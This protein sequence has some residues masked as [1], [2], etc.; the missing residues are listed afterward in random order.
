MMQPFNLKEISLHV[1]SSIKIVSTIIYRIKY[2]QRK[3][4]SI[5]V[6]FIMNILLKHV[7]KIIKQ[8]KDTKNIL[9]T[10]DFSQHI[11]AEM[12]Q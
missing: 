11:L 9:C 4:E 8:I 10:L 2:V 12:L 7:R 1:S 5:S 6:I 3:F